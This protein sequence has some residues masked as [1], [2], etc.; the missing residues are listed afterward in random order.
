MR[1]IAAASLCAVLLA[2]CAADGPPRQPQA[3]NVAPNLWRV[4]AT[5][6][7]QPRSRLRALRRA[8]DLTLTRGGDWFRV[9]ERQHGADIG[10]DDPGASSFD[11]GDLAD[12]GSGAM[13]TLEIEIGRGPAP[14]DR[15]VYDA[16]QV[17]SAG[18]GPR[19]PGPDR[20]RY[21]SRV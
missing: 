13:T 7:S 15:D 5:A 14:I 19:A 9:L 1:A 4:G 11:G 3:V 8:A 12:E 20:S 10:G 2:G 6:S 16:R 17:A 21:G 18:R